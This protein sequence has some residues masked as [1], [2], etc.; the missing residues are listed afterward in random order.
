MTSSPFMT[1]TVVGKSQELI[2]THVSSLI[3]SLNRDETYRLPLFTHNAVGVVG[4]KL[5]S[6]HTQQTIK[7]HRSVFVSSRDCFPSF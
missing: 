7:I 3:C 4:G 5:S 1:H 6:I 2:M